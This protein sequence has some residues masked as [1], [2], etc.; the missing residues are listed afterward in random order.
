LGLAAYQ[1]QKTADCCGIAAVVGT[2]ANAEQDSRD[3]LLEGLSALKNRGYDS[4]G[5]ATIPST[6]GSMVSFCFL[7]GGSDF[8]S[9][10]F[11][12]HCQ[13]FRLLPSLPTAI[14]TKLTALISSERIR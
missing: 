13:G 12:T 1:Q 9:E 3:F 10:L 2:P 11:F 14:V 8:L 5:M 7:G 4:A 6:G